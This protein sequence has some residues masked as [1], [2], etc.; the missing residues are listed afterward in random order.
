VLAILAAP[1]TAAAQETETPAPEEGESTG[2]APE[3]DGAAPGEATEEPAAA[4]S[5]PAPPPPVV[6]IPITIGRVPAE[7]ATAIRDAVAEQLRPSVRRREVVTL[8]DEEKLATA[9][10]CEDAA[11]IGSIVA[12]EGATSGVLVRMERRR[13][14]DPLTLMIGVVD[15]VSGANRG[16]P[17]NGEIPREDLEAPAELLAPLIAQLASLMPAPPR[18]TTLLVASNIDEATVSVDGQE[19]GTTPIAPGDIAPGEH[20]VS[21]S[22]PGYLVQSHRIEIAAGQAARLN[23]DLEPTP[24]TAAGDAADLSAG[25]GGGEAGGGSTGGGDSILTQWWF[26]TAIGGAVVLGVLIGVIAAVASGP[27]QE[28]AILVPPIVP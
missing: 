16:D 28:E 11:C 19:V 3:A 8:D 15:P 22:R 23:F 13:P 9:A 14:R 7:T 2:E 24:E 25:F 1:T 27:E 17:V 6:I 21:V 26:W 18:R 12:G 10:A 20:T 4:E 5:A